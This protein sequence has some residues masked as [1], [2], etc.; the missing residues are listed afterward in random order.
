MLCEQTEDGPSSLISSDLIQDHISA[1]NIELRR[2]FLNIESLD[3]TIVN[4]GRPPVRA[5]AK[6]SSREIYLQIQTF[7]ETPIKVTIE[8]NCIF[9]L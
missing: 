4:K 3:L 7:V 9:G 8:L 5:T 2:G 1:R 6:Q